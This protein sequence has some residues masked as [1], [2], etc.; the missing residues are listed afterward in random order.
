L[1]ATARQLTDDGEYDNINPQA[2]AMWWPVD[3]AL[4]GGDTQGDKYASLV[5]TDHGFVLMT[6]GPVYSGDRI[7]G[8]TF[9]G[10]YLV[11]LAERLKLQSV[12]DVTIYDYNGLPIASTL[13]S[14]DERSQVLKIP[15]A[16]LARIFG[17]PEATDRNS[18]NY[19]ERDFD[20]AYGLLR[21][22]G[23]VIG[24]YSVALPT[25]FIAAA[26]GR[27]RLEMSVLVAIAVAAILI[28]G[29]MVSKRITDP[30]LSLARTAAR[31][32]AGDT[33]ARSD[34]RSADE[35]GALAVTFDRM[36]ENLEE[37]AARL[38]RQYLGTVK[39]L[40]SAIDA[41]DPYTLGH[42]IRVGQLGRLLGA[43]L[44]LP[45]PLLTE[46][47]RRLSP[48]Y[49]QDRC[50]R[51]GAAEAGQADDG[52]EGNHPAP[53]G[54]GSLDPQDGRCLRRGHRHCP[55]SSRAL[56]RFRLSGQA[57][58]GRSADRRAYR[59]CSRCVRCSHDRAALQAGNAR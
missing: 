41:R 54:A 49:R 27:T 7:V 12:A 52:R 48:R 55:W 17:S 18:L 37:Y 24:V 13:V 5:E 20:L 51:L 23:N 15:G 56:E 16:E 39:A 28:V 21:V 43:K 53:P 1:Y 10:T 34:V 44:E 50:S 59:C 8:A 58:R 19:A 36:A 3:R 14:E 31:L 4:Q 45:E 38:Q 26:G 29:Y 35:V 32:S 42:S 6:A 22:R 40:T 2:A 47:D 30:I 33:G 57:S 46:I 11:S 9:A 25:D